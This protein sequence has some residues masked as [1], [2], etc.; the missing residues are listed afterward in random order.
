MK[1]KHSIYGINPMGK[2]THRFNIVNDNGVQV[3]LLDY[4]AAWLQTI[5]PDKNN[6]LSPIMPKAMPSSPIVQLIHPEYGLLNIDVS[7]LHFEATIQHKPEGIK[8][9][10]TQEIAYESRLLGKLQQSYYFNEENQLKID[11]ELFCTSETYIH[12]TMPTHFNLLGSDEHSIAS[13][14]LMIHSYKHLQNGTLVNSLGTAFNFSK[15]GEI[16]QIISTENRK[17]E[18]LYLINKSFNRWAAIGKLL[19]AESG[20][21]IELVSNQAYLHIA[22][23]S[24]FQSLCLSP[25]AA[26]LQSPLSNKIY[27]P[28]AESYMFQS[29]YTFTT[30]DRGHKH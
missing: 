29:R 15:G 27:C 20:R 5:A 10:F 24:P 2:K 12:A 18:A 23:T 21:V 28:A 22:T 14:Q 17:C 30:I 1:I 11:T 25:Q 3:S 19:S 26:P 4:G 9:S 13:H 16:Q 7:T 6:I 8:I